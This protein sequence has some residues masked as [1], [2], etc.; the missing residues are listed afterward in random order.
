M[1]VREKGFTNKQMS[2]LTGACLSK[3][4]ALPAIAVR[5]DHPATPTVTLTADLFPTVEAM[6]GGAGCIPYHGDVPRDDP[7]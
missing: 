5:H 3:H 7:E 4:E 1:T 6:N 2:Q